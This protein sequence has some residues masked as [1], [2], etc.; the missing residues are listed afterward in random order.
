MCTHDAIERSCALQAS[1]RMSLFQAC[2]AFF[3][4]RSDVHGRHRGSSWEFACGAANYRENE[5]L[6]MSACIHTDRV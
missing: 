4:A 1:C 3:L 5:M 6:S 2:S